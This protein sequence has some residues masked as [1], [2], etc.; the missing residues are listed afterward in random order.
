VAAALPDLRL[1]ELVVFMDVDVARVLALSGSAK[2]WSLPTSISVYAGKPLFL[3]SSSLS[4][5]GT[6]SS[7][8]EW[9]IVVFSFTVV[10]EPYFFHAG[11][12]S[13]SGVSPASRF[14]AMAPPLDDP[15]TTSG[16][17][18]SNSAWA[19]LQ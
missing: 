6:T 15:T 13:T 14:M 4:A 7:V 9:R 3:T 19:S 10:A 1:V 18:S 5:Y 8:R 2:R 12:S 11:Q 16:R 17:C